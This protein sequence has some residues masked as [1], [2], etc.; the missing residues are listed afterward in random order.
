MILT[1]PAQADNP[2]IFANTAF[3]VLTGYEM[4]EAIGRNC[5]FLQGPDTDKNTVLEIRAALRSG[6]PVHREILNY[7]KD[8]E[9]FWNDL[10]ID[11]IKGDNGQLAGFVGVQFRTTAGI[12]AQV[13]QVE[14]EFRLQSVVDNLPGYIFRRVLRPDGIIAA[15]Y[16]GKLVSSIIGLP[17][18]RTVTNA[19]FYRHIH[20]EDLE[21]LMR[22]IANSGAA[23]SLFSEEFRLISSKGV[24]H[25]FRSVA[26]ARRAPN[27]EIIWDGFALE[28]TAEKAAESQ[29]AFLAFHDS[30][31]GLSNRSLFKLGLRKAIDTTA[32]EHDRIGVF[33]IDLDSF[34][35]IN[36]LLGQSA[37][38]D[39]LRAIG[40][41]LA[42]IASGISGTVARLGGDEFALLVPTLPPDRSISEFADTICADLARPLPMAGDE[43]VV[44]A[45]V[46]AAI[47]PRPR[48]PGQLEAADAGSELLKQADLALR[49]AKREGAGTC[50]IYAAEFDDR[51]LNR[52]A[53]KQSLH[54]A[55]I[56]KQFTLHYQPLVDLA[57]GHIIGAEA[58]VRWDHPELGMQRPDLF[59][60]LAE[61]SGLILPLGAWVMEETMRQGQAWREQGIDTPR[62]AINVSSVQ[63][64]KPGFIAA[65]ETALDNTGADPQDFEFELTE[66][67][68]IEAT[69]EVFS[70]LGKMKTLGFSLSID[71]FGTGH[72]TFRYLR[73]FPVDKIKIDQTFIRK[74]VI[75]SSDAIIVRAMIALAGS[76]GVAILAEGIETT[77]QR[78]FLRDEG[79]R[80]GQG[81]LFSMP[82]TAEDFGWMLQTHVSLPMSEVYPPPQ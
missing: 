56:E 23:L 4:C 58:L 16:F 49:A 34:Q 44:Q 71:D 26:P 37:G 32:R 5:R 61:A 19:D 82:L 30:L 59:I 46:G 72:S 42:I 51:N 74:L 41:R 27:G 52:M 35:E 43:I 60:P 57:T 8:G 38:D 6:T 36:D 2:I 73:D 70:L 33:L 3:T 53:L 80:A 78:D 9:P 54:R 18:G 50:R 67:L 55:V 10:M 66:G 11:P 12:I 75:N 17:E 69:T 22:A 7:R 62:L 68:L 48:D 63:L 79:C 13:A 81:F 21:R 64:Q 14:A 28:I 31:T 1:D 40:Q 24:I 29:L 77:M 65:V 20:P 76:L 15:P 39:V 25:W 45:C 47:F